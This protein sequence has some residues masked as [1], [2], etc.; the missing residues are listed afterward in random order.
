MVSALNRANNF[1]AEQESKAGKNI[2]IK[3]VPSCCPV[4]KSETRNSKHFICTG[5]KVT[6]FI[7]LL[8]I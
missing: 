7:S 6:M 8:T 3:N 4:T 2:D 1:L 5:Q